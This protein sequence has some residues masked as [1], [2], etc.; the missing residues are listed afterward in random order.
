MLGAGADG[1]SSTCGAGY[2][3]LDKLCRRRWLDEKVG[4]E[5]GGPKGRCSTG[6]SSHVDGTFESLRAISRGPS[7]VNLRYQDIVSPS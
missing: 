3:A 7:I 6:H 5:I 1:L 2:V 4:A